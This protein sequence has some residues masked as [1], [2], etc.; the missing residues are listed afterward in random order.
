MLNRILALALTTI[1]AGCTT[2][3][4]QTPL[5]SAP[6]ALLIQCERP[7]PIPAVQA[8]TASHA[9]EAVTDNYARHHR[10]ADRADALQSWVKEQAKVSPQ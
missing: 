2:L 6:Q 1:G 5:P 8:T 3:H 4:P 10:C 7:Q 9:L